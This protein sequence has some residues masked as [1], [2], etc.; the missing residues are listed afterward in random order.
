MLDE[1]RCCVDNG[2]AQR[3]AMKTKNLIICHFLILN[4]LIFR[5]F[6]QDTINLINGYGL[7]YI[8]QPGSLMEAAHSSWYYP[9]KIDRKLPFWNYAGIHYRRKDQ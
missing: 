8:N 6:W 4:F 7:I 3:L 2:K 9:K 5:I 1:N